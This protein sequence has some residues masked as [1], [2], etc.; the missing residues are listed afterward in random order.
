MEAYILC[1]S[2]TSD[3]L[4]V[5]LNKYAKAIMAMGGKV[6]IRIR[7]LPV[8]T[9]PG[10]HRY[11][12]GIYIPNIITQ[13]KDLNGTTLSMAEVDLINKRDANNGAFKLVEVDGDEAIIFNELQTSKMTVPE[14]NSFIAN[15]DL[16]WSEKGITPP[17]ERP[18]NH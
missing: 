6:E 11:Y 17:D 9:G 18:D 16:Y 8:Q 10:H 3:T 1:P 12:R 4:T 7:P 5:P 2:T 14:F 13:N 15:C